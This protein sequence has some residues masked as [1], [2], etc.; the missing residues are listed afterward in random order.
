M[1]TLE[2]K[3]L[4]FSICRKISQI[5]PE[6][7]NKLSDPAIFGFNRSFL[8]ALEDS[9]L[10]EEDPYYLIFHTN[11]KD[12]A[13]LAV[14][15]T[16]TMDFSH[17]DRDHPESVYKVL[18][19]WYPG[20]MQIKVLEC[21]FLTALGKGFHR[22]GGEPHT[23]MTN[24]TRALEELALDNGADIILVRDVPESAA[25]QMREMKK[26]GFLPLRGYPLAVLDLHWGSFEEYYDTLKPGRRKEFRKKLRK[27]DTYGM[28]VRLLT[29]WD[30]YIPQLLEQWNE[31]ES[32]SDYHHEKLTAPYF[33][34]LQDT[35]GTDSFILGLFEKEKLLG[36]SLIHETP[37]ELFCSYVGLDY[38]YSQSRNSYFI[39]N[40]KILEE[41]FRRGKE[42]INLGITSYD[43]KQ[44]MGCRLIPQTYY[45]KSWR[46]PETTRGIQKYLEDSIPRTITSHSSFK[47]VAYP[48]TDLEK[49]A[50]S[51]SPE[52]SR[53]DPFERLYSF[54]RSHILKFL[55]LYTFF[56]EF[57]S[58]QTPEVFY[59]GRRILM[60][61]SNSYRG[62][63]ARKEVRDAAREAISRYGTGC[64]GSPLLN[65]TLDIHQKLAGAL[66]EYTGKEDALLY[67]TGYQA[68]LG[69][70]STLAKPGVV[71]LMDERCHASLID[72]VL[73]SR[74]RLIRYKHTD[75]A[76]LEKKLREH[77]GSSLLIVTDS[78]FSMEGTTV[79]LKKLVSL[80]EEYHARLMIDESHAIGV[81]GPR[82]AGLAAREGLSERIDVL[83]GTFSKSLAA[84]G[85][86]IASDN[87]LIATLKHESRG[88]IFSASLA[89]PLIGAVSKALEIIGR[90]EEQRLILIQNTAYMADSL[91]SLGYEVTRSEGAIIP[92]YCRDEL[93]TF[94]LY[95]KLFDRGVFV[96]PVVSPAVPKGSELLRITLMAT[97][98]RQEIDKALQVFRE[99]KTDNFPQNEKEKNER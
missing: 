2:Q 36:F 89:P 58:A 88:H 53:P 90:E 34:R 54:S 5:P 31:V 52:P 46:D 63:A 25:E 13:G 9:S 12:L 30:H 8:Q 69:A 10:Y 78:L 14:A 42:R 93:L 29:R 7:W 75:M 27:L 84:Q 86:F 45:V 22:S 43:F 59:K 39:L 74:A 3:K 96:N 18:N 47:E 64:S 76:S 68:N 87:S 28:E 49:E 50:S 66:A 23:F 70:L 55:N 17:F 24:L 41:G 99:V 71:V 35:P 83:M 92:L 85:G 40:L 81:I 38:E 21:G 19:Q 61:G 48:G 95:R 16:L 44:L 15:Y 4:T 1:K 26:R 98:T 94:A 80:K 79:P 32:R 33:A 57:E 56:P 82:G 73:L 91:A 20:I 97:H 67:S 72:G 65:G 60:M 37:E 77:R 51:P 62:L 11:G 6:V